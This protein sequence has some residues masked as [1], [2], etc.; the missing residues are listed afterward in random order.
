M[1]NAMIIRG[2]AVNRRAG[3]SFEHCS[4][5]VVRCLVRYV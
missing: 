4:N 1:P 5:K 3:E 2:R